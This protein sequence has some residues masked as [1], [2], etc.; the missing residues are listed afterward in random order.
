MRRSVLQAMCVAVLSLLGACATAG[1]PV[2]VP[3]AVAADEVSNPSGCAIDSSVSPPRPE[4]GSRW[5]FVYGGKVTAVNGQT[6]TP[7]YWDQRPTIAYVFGG[8]PAMAAGLQVGDTI[9]AV[10]G[11]DALETRALHHPRLGARY[12]FDLRRGAQAFSVSY[13]LV[14]PTWCM[15]EWTPP[16]GTIDT[17]T[18]PTG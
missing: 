4:F 9:A 6:F 18:M 17:R 11:T 14:Q 15:S 8:S 3:A 10:N 7:G 2:L 1:D 16:H 13:E 5:G 12:Q